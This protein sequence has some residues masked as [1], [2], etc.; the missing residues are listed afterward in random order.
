MKV[1]Q[2]PNLA[3]ITPYDVLTNIVSQQAQNDFNL[4]IYHGSLEN[5]ARIAQNLDPNFYDVIISRGGTAEYIKRATTIPVVRILTSAIDLLQV[6]LPY[7]SVIKKIAFFNYQNKLTGVDLIANAL[8]IQ[9]DEYVFNDA[10]DINRFMIYCLSKHYDLVVGGTPALTIANEYGLKG[11]LIENGFESVASALR[12][13]MAITETKHRQNSYMA[14]LEIILSSI[15]EGIIVTDINNRVIIFNQSAQRIFGMDEKDVIG[16]SVESVIKNTRIN[17]V[18][19][20]K[21]PEIG[22]LQ[23]IGN[24]AIFTSRIPIFMGDE[25]IGVVC[26]FTD[27]PQIKKAEKII[28]GRLKKSGFSTKY[29]FNDILTNNSKMKEIIRLSKIYSSTDSPILIHG[30]SGTGKELFAQS[31]HATSHRKNGP[32]VAINCAAIPETLLETELFGYEGGAFT[33]AKREGKEGLIE[34]AH[35]GTLFLDEI[36]ELPRALQSR[37]LRVLQEYEIMRVGGKDVIPVDIRIIGATNKDL[38]ELSLKGDFRLD[39]YYRLNVLPLNIPSLME[40][41]DDIYFLA[42]KFLNKEEKTPQLSDVINELSI[43]NWPGNIR[44]LKAVIDR[45]SLVSDS[46]PSL[47]W[48]EILQLTGFKIEMNEHAIHTNL[49]LDITLGE[50]KRIIEDAEQKVITFYMEY[51]NYNQEAV[52]KKLGISKMSL[53]RK[54]KL[55]S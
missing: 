31:I 4:H 5:A 30:E 50:L 17:E 32:F 52:A 48:K 33:G 11:V 26:S 12:E 36:G 18:S 34:L 3:L 13:A 1:N 43:Y 38:K 14:R 8:G 27:A 15:A 46:F 22:Q 29:T 35:N 9:I 53:W 6:V 2:L 28:R 20:S 7:K 25:C 47:T 55:K 16:K 10:N 23:E 21:A 49:M 39:L 51:F 24:T 37:L 44:E 40:R 41:G 42:K 54:S 19:K 45:L